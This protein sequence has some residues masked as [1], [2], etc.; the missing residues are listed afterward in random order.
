[1]REACDISSRVGEICYEAELDRIGHAH[2]HDGNGRGGLLGGYGRLGCSHEHDVDP[3]L[4]Q[5]GHELP[6]LLLTPVR[7]ATPLY[8]RTLSLNVSKTTQPLI[9][10]T[11]KARRTCVGAEV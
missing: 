3:T 5:V 8:Q 10:R 1:M 2:K 4:D 6:E 7:A 11:L 9:E